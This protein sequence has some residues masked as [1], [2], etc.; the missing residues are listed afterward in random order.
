MP[1]RLS[2]EEI[3]NLTNFLEDEEN[4]NNPP[5]VLTQ[6]MIDDYAEFL[7]NEESSGINREFS[8]SLYLQNMKIKKVLEDSLEEVRKP[9][10]TRLQWMSK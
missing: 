10:L 6:E 9:K 8:S 4:S 3:D 2:Q 7:D 1:N 5:N